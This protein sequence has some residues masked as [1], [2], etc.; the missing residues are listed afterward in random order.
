MSRCTSTFEIGGLVAA[1]VLALSAGAAVAQEAAAPPP[2]ACAATDA[3]LPPALAG[4]T[5]KRPLVSAT[6]AA[7]LAAATLTLGQSAQ[8]TLHGTREVAYAAQPAKPG[9]SVA[10][11]GLLSFSVTKAATY[12]V[13]LSSGA[14]VDVVRDGA[15]TTSTAHGHGPAC[16]TLR[17]MVDYPLQPG[18]Y[19][20]QIS[21][22]ADPQLAV[23]VAEVR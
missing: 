16:S 19:V 1:A 18:S 6:S 5:A 4:W 22:N 3:A 15:L 13:G 9:G 11:G 2:A 21:A 23:M 17:K 8:V 14:W 20:L 10:H 12:R 7:G